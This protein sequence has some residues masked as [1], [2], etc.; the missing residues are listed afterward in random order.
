MKKS[1]CCIFILL[2]FSSAF[3]L[4]KSQTGSKAP[5]EPF[6]LVYEKELNFDF[7]NER[8]L[9]QNETSIMSTPI[10]INESE[11]A[12]I[13]RISN[14][15]EYNY[16]FEILNISDNTF[17]QYDLPF[18]T[19]YVEIQEINYSKSKGEKNGR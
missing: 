14:L 16:K 10:I 12:M 15:T 19:G 1:I 11:I 9:K 8:N 2:I 5:S 13:I 7:W 17:V 6:T 4:P 3:S 18:L